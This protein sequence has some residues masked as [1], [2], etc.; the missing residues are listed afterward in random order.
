MDWPDPVEGDIVAL[1]LREHLGRSTPLGEGVVVQVKPFS[2]TVVIEH[3]LDGPRCTET[4]NL[5]TGAS[6][7]KGQ[8]AVRVF[9]SRGQAEDERRRADAL[10]VLRMHHLT[11]AGGR[12]T[13]ATEP[14]ERLAVVLI[15]A[16]PTTESER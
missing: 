3:G 2:G 15:E 14:L 8:L 5:T 9:M 7:H 10:E 6:L 4:F 1:C 11:P 16:E 13:I 12:L